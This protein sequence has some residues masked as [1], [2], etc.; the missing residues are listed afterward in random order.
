IPL[1]VLLG[2]LHRLILD[3]EYENNE[4][5]QEVDMNTKHQYP[6]S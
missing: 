6:I 1:A 2:D 5:D 3:V 4:H